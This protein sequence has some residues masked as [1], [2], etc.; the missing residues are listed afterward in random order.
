MGR[1]A[2]VV[3]CN[4]GRYLQGGG[5]TVSGNAPGMHVVGEKSW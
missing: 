4:T 1:V 5:G 3:S 2:R